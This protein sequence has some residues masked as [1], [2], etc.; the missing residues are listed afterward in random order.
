MWLGGFSSGSGC[1][2]SLLPVHVVELGSDGSSPSPLLPS[3]EPLLKELAT[4][5]FFLLQLLNPPRQLLE[6]LSVQTKSEGVG[7]Q[8][9]DV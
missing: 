5:E 9:E 3:I 8:A 1:E 4:P 7:D 6:F 2:V